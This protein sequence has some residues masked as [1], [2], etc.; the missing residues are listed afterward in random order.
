VLGPRAI[1]NATGLFCGLVHVWGSVYSRLCVREPSWN[2]QVPRAPLPENGLP[3]IREMSCISSEGVAPPSSLL[4]AHAP[5][6]LPSP[7]SGLTSCRWSLQVATGPCWSIGPSRRYLCGSFPRCL[8]PYHDGLQVALTCYFPCNIGLPQKSYRSAYRNIPLSDFTA[9]GIFEV[10]AIPL[11]SGLM[12]CS[13]PWSLPPCS[14]LQ[15]GRWLLRPS[16][17]RVVTSAC[18]G[19]ASRPNQAIDGTG[20]LT[21]LDSQPCRLLRSFIPYNMP[22]Y[23]GARRI[24][25]KP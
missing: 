13:P 23:P 9:E 6:L 1:C 24:T 16:P 19:Y 7:T 20:T 18:L 15:G 12:V 22:V 11:C 21:P 10:A 2:R 17:S 3:L 25:A 4:R 8:G 5:D 14:F